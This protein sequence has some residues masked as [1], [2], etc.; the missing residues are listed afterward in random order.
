MWA[1]CLCWSQ[2]NCIL[3]VGQMI[4]G[5]QIQYTNI[6]KGLNKPFLKLFYHIVLPYSSN[7][8]DYRPLTARNGHDLHYCFYLS[9]RKKKQNTFSF[10]IV[11]IM[12]E[13]GLGFLELFAITTGFLLLLIDIFHIIIQLY[14]YPELF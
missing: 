8:L 3:Q 2:R 11:H 4:I 14:G 9:L 7:C 6:W 5:H 13:Y 12:N 1:W 10:D